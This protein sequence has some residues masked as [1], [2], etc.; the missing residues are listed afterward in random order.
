MAAIPVP[1]IVWGLKKDI[2]TLKKQVKALEDKLNESSP[3]QER[4]V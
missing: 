3:L 2:D 1:P 4:T